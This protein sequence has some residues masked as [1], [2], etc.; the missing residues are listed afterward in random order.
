MQKT[1]PNFKGTGLST[2]SSLWAVKKPN[3]SFPKSSLISTRG[4]QLKTISAFQLED[5]PGAKQKYGKIFLFFFIT[6]WNTPRN[7]ETSRKSK[8]TWKML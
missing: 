1:M 2:I 6:P 3:H 5:T 4:S 8:R 7:E